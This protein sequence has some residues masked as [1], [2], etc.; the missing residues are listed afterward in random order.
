MRKGKF[1]QNKDTAAIRAASTRLVLEKTDRI[2]GMRNVNVVVESSN[3]EA[4]AFTD[5]LKITINSKYEPLSS[6]LVK[7]FN[8]R[9]MFI[10]TGLNY[11]EL[12]H[13]MFMPRL[14]SD[15]VKGIRNDGSFN[16]FNILQDQTD[17]TAFV[18]LYEPAAS[19]FTGLVMNYMMESLLSSNYPL[20]SGRL[21]IP[22]SL[23]DKFANHYRKPK[24]IDDIDAIVTQYK[25]L[26]HPND[27]KEMRKLVNDFQKILQD[28]SPQFQDHNIVSGNP[29]VS[30]AK[31]LQTEE[32]IVNDDLEESPEEENTEDTIDESEGQGQDEKDEQS[33]DEPASDEAEDS[34]SDEEGSSEGKGASS[35]SNGE[36]KE[37]SVEDLVDAIEDVID[38][39]IEKVSDELSS[40]I[41]S[42]RDHESDYRSLSLNEPGFLRRTI[43]PEM[44][45]VARRCM[46]E[47]RVA[48]EQHSPGWHNNQRS[49][50]LN[51]R[52]Y[53]KALQ[54]NEF[55]YRKW[56]EGVHD[57]LDFEVVFL[58]DC[59]YSMDGLDIKDASKALWILKRTFEEYD[60][61]TSVIG[62]SD[63]AMSLM[64]R[65]KKEDP[66]YYRLYNVNG[67][68]SV[69]PAVQEA[70]RILAVTRKPL[71][72]VVIVT[73][74]MF[75]DRELAMS[76][77]ADAHGIYAIVGINTHVDHY[78]GYEN[79]IHTQQITNAK[80]LVDVVKNLALRIA[81]ERLTRRAH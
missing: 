63:D 38:D 26:T 41:E 12:A 66:G 31:E 14:H 6:S 29:Q 46:D 51:T 78:N 61:V 43:E 36:V 56:S 74:G 81:E 30:K 9:D 10:V 21:F 69:A 71:R 32:E 27:D 34:P 52:Q 53:A 54:G 75:A 80:E 1:L 7:G 13:C 49:G 40:R 24:L 19:Y 3:V 47:F 48:M 76:K 77:I 50:R 72:L 37:Q 2:L 57:A 55:V 59:S 33:E 70:N 16:A 60:A 15:L 67:G 17:E 11:H 28:T 18:K 42:I 23:R 64:Q 4:P 73:D 68:T 25:K 20:V 45:N 22:K 65:G 5:G 62:F 39:S 35:S 44:V 79:V 8:T 58:L